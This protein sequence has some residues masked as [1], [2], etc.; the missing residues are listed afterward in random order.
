MFASFVVDGGVDGVR[1]QGFWLVVTGGE[2]AVRLESSGP[3]GGGAEF[4][5][6][7]RG[8]LTGPATSS[9]VAGCFRKTGI[10]SLNPLT[11]LRIVV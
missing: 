1:F 2:D 9:E 4:F 8:V 10:D 3:L 11:A 5:E 6:D 7:G